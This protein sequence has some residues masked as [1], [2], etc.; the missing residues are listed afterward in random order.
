MH[1]NFSAFRGIVIVGQ[2][3]IHFSRG[4]PMGNRTRGCQRCK[5]PI[6]AERL[7]GLPETRLCLQCSQEVGSDFKMQGSTENLA[8]TSSLK[9]NWGGIYI[10]K[11]RRRIEPKE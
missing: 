6:S 11:K 2:E 10:E 4:F 5:Q 1:W 8:K 7:A 9:K 3:T